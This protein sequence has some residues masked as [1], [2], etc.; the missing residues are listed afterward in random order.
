MLRLFLT[1]TAVLMALA[2]LSVA[3]ACA[4]HHGAQHEVVG[5][6]K[7]ETVEIGPL[8]MSG[9]Y[10]LPTPP[11]TRNGAI[12]LHIEN[13]AQHAD[14]L[15]SVTAAETAQKVELHT[16]TIDASGIMRMRLVSSFEVPPN[17]AL[18]LEPAGDH[19]MLIGLKHPLEAGKT[20]PVTMKFETAGER[21]FQIPILAPAGDAIRSD[22][23]AVQHEDHSHH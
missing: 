6:G 10:A 19:I 8:R 4:E 21:T 11:A 18:T 15:I 14:R 16:Q 17:G 13:A 9:F 23:T 5:V 20:L 3:Q 2:S 7:T 12:F 22:D 1:G